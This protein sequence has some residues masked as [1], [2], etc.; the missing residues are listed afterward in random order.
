MTYSEVYDEISKGKSSCNLLIGNGF[1]I[2][3]DDAFKIKEDGNGAVADE[4]IKMFIN[5]DDK[6]DNSQ[7]LKINSYDYP[8]IMFWQVAR[9]HPKS[10][11]MIRESEVRNCFQF[12]KIYLKRGKVFTTNYDML[13]PWAITIR[14]EI[15]GAADSKVKSVDILPYNDG[16][17]LLKDDRLY[18]K[19]SSK[20]NIFYCHGA[21]GFR[22]DNNGFSKSKY[23]MCSVAPIINSFLENEGHPF[24]PTVSGTSA[25]EKQNQIERSLYFS[26]CFDVL[27]KIKGSL[28]ILGLSFISNDDHIV[29][30]IK[31]A[32]EASPELKVYY[33]Y[34]T[35]VDKFI[36]KKVLEDNNG[37]RVSGYFDS[38]TADIWRLSSSASVRTEKKYDPLNSFLKIMSKRG[39]SKV[40]LSFAEI[41]SIINDRLPDSAA[42]YSSWWS[43]DS[44]HTQTRAWLD[45]GYRAKVHLKKRT[46]DFINQQNC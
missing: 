43:S 14:S 33:G 3:F 6:A 40:S 13:L 31:E 39:E 5:T 21:M 7:L 29:K 23:S 42:S 28:V 25:K 36:A 10:I 30:T 35:T 12:L 19:S 37:I 24:P 38:S 9:K 4:I 11:E 16:F 1:S 34:F 8:R 41:E 27:H 44:H 26:N 45:A 2:A 20:Q 22:E 46:V 18:W 32:Q 15:T 17:T